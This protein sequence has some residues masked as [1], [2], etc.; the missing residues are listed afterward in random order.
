MAESVQNIIASIYGEMNVSPVELA[1]QDIEQALTDTVRGMF[2]DLK[3]SLR[4]VTLTDE[5]D[6]Q[7]L[8]QPDE[9]YAIEKND[10]GYG[11]YFDP[12]ILRAK[13]TSRPITDQS[14]VDCITVPLAAFADHESQ[15]EIICS[16]SGS[17]TTT[18]R[19][20]RINQ[21]PEFIARMIWRV[22]YTASAGAILFSGDNPPV[23]SDYIPYLKI[24]TML[25]CV[26]LVRSK[27]TDWKEW[28]QENLSILAAEMN[29]WQNKWQRFCD[30]S[31]EPEEQS[32]LPYNSF[33]S[34]G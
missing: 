17:L 15:S 24:K 7:L 11:D 22:R 13:D 25:R 8:L 10:A 23:P 19:R 12:I 20:V 34:R 31:D 32:F 16:F 1:L 29:D 5:T 30:S 27:S 18:R 2:A 33:R 6:C 21:K 28:K 14:F 4:D 3:V 26:R 9:T